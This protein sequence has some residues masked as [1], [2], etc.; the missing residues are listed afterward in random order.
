MKLTFISQ[1][2]DANSDGGVEWDEFM[3]YLLLENQTLNLM[4]E[5]V[6]LCS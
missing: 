4:K 1:K 6:A 5:E 3:N 2:I